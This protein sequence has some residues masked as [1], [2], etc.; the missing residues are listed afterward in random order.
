[1]KIF[2][3]FIVVQTYTN[4]G[5]RLLDKKNDF[6]Q[7]LIGR[8]LK[9]S[10]PYPYRVFTHRLPYNKGL[11]HLGPIRIKASLVMGQLITFQIKLLIIEWFAFSDTNYQN[12]CNKYLFIA[13]RPSTR[14]MKTSMLKIRTISYTQL[15]ELFFFLAHNY[16]VNTNFAIQ[17]LIHLPK[18]LL[19][20]PIIEPLFVSQKCCL[21]IYK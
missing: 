8:V 3:I 20:Y 2:Y 11:L 9:R 1:M 13:S 12:N 5:N 16:T 10:G 17:Y 21:V 15:C 6:Y 14:E 7:I 19:F 18:L 4:C